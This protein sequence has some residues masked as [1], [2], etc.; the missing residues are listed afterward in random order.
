M[1][2]FIST[3]FL[4][5]S[6][7]VSILA[8]PTGQRDVAQVRHDLQETSH[9]VAKL[10]GE[11]TS[12]GS[13]VTIQQAMAIRQDVEELHQRID[14]STMDVKGIH[15]VSDSEG[16]EIFG[17]VQNFA[18]TIMHLLESIYMKKGAFFALS[19]AVIPLIRAELQSLHKA[20][21]DLGD[22]LTDVA[23]NSVKSEAMNLKKSIDAMFDKVIAYYNQ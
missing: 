21:F 9:A 23:P 5:A 16:K 2:K 12:L 10:D 7:A 15:G 3:V 6:I 20:S 8:S 13:P 4:I 17:D 1:V 11:V 19:R 18:P 14:R 22:A